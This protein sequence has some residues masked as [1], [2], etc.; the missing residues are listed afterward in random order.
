MTRKDVEDIALL[1]RL[2]TNE[3]ETDR[4][5]RDLGSILGY[6]DKLRALDTQG[7]EPMT[8]AVPMDCPLRDDVVASSLT[9]EAALG[10]APRRSDD[11]FEVPRIIEINGEGG[12]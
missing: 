2:R 12:K 1:A 3:A 7:V 11:F 10:D 4:L 8:H 9:S 5:Q 6:I